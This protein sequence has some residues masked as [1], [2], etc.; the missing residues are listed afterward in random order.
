MESP[1]TLKNKY[2]LHVLISDAQDVLRL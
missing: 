2:C 1:G